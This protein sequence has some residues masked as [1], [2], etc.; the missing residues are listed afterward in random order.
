[1]AEALL[2]RYGPNFAVVIGGMAGSLAILFL[3]LPVPREWLFSLESVV[4]WTLVSMAAASA[5]WPLAQR[6]V[7]AAGDPVAT[8]CDSTE[9]RQGFLRA[10]R[11]TAGLAGALV[12]CSVPVMSL[13]QSG[14]TTHYHVGGLLPFSDASNYLFGSS[15]LLNQGMLDPWNVRRPLN[16]GFLAVRLALTG[17]DLQWAL[18]LQIW[19]VAA[20]SF[21]ASRAVA[22]SHGLASGLLLFALLYQFE[23]PYLATTLSENLGLCFGCLSFAA[24]WA[25]CA[26]GRLLVPA[27]CGLALLTLGL[28]ARAGAFLVLPAL[29]IWAVAQAGA[30]LRDRLAAAVVGIA[31]I[32]AGFLLS[33]FLLLAGFGASTGMPHENFSVVL[34]GLAVGGKG[35][36]QVYADHPEVVAL[37]GQQGSR[38][39]A[40]HVY[41]L[42]WR[43]IRTN[44]THFMGAYAQGM[45][46]YSRD[47][48]DF[49]REAE[50]VGHG[51]A[52]REG[53]LLLPLKACALLAIWLLVR[54]WREPRSR[55]LT[56]ALI[57]TFVS[58]P[59]LY[60]DGGSRA[61]AATVPFAASLPAIGLAFLRRPWWPFQNSL[62]PLRPL[63]AASP[64][65]VSILGATLTFGGILTVGSTVGPVLAAGLHPHPTFVRVACPAGQ[66]PAVFHVGNGSPYLRILQGVEGRVPLLSPEQF[67]ADPGF[68]GVELA[69]AL[70]KVMPGSWLILAYDLQTDE[71]SGGGESDK[72]VSGLQTWV[73]VRDALGPLQPGKYVR[74][75]GEF[76]RDVSGSSRV[77][78]A[79]T[80]GVLESNSDR[81]VTVLHAAQ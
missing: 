74:V 16:A 76:D 40:E 23:R 36:S 15:S 78:H 39:A 1:M 45:W 26:S 35:W 53:P 9:A 38:A 44:P 11:G 20:S 48:F 37:M 25:G 71:R 8:D 56:E 81:S 80:V 3:K 27:G 46:L 43:E 59:F 19:L 42:A 28:N 7:S 70:R 29:V 68:R 67:Q 5:L 24:L 65:D 54:H 10:I 75:C 30:A 73:V 2:R 51:S 77:L 47:L 64:T 31:G 58:A 66:F 21:L 60:Y 52:L 57:G 55:L 13:W 22:R 14:R 6:A 61:F 4:F 49:V 12:L 72:H 62:W 63:P 33:G 69:P 41:G 79:V 17:E 32:A 18:V 34:Y 50:W